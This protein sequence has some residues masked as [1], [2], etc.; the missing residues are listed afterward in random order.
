MISEVLLKGRTIAKYITQTK[1]VM[2]DGTTPKAS[3]IVLRSL[4]RL[5]PFNVFSFLGAEGRG[6]H[7]SISNT[8]VVDVVKFK[9]KMDSEID[10][11]LLGKSTE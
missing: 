3:D 9:A 8:Y 1:V 6:W 4:C 2:E 5:I 7:D 11:E 10:L